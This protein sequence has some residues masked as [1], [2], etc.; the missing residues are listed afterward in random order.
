MKIYQLKI[1]KMKMP[2]GI[3]RYGQILDAALRIQ[4]PDAAS[5]TGL[6]EA[7]DLPCWLDQV[8]D[9]LAEE[10][11]RHRIRVLI[12]TGI[13]NL[14]RRLTTAEWTEF[15]R[16]ISRLEDQ[17]RPTIAVIDG[18]AAGPAC[19]LALAC[20]WRI[21]TRRAS[22]QESAAPESRASIGIHPSAGHSGLRWASRL[23]G[24]IGPTL[25]LELI[26]TGRTL[27]SEE[28]SSVG[29]LQRQVESRDTALQ[30]ASQLAARLAAG[31]PLS[32]EWANE[33]VRRGAQL[34][35]EAGLAVETG[36][37]TRSV[38]TPDA[39]EGVRAFLEKRP[40]RFTGD[41]LSEPRPG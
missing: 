27:S 33:A 28:A 8:L 14:S 25:T 38:A 13:E 16:A 19:E 29:I 40:P 36:L 5:Q 1:Y 15:R 22:F 18:H 41:Q 34:P 11:A 20:H 24:I 23:T 4:L 7:A 21:G 26:L 37:F 30:L 32:I 17:G 31:A 12:L 39:R 35:L 2:E 3:E 10:P 9:Q 6:D